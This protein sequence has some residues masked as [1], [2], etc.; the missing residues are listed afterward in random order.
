MRPEPAASESGGPRGGLPWSARSRPA[1]DGACA[2]GEEPASTR[3]RS[4]RSSLPRL[5]LREPRVEL[6]VLEVVTVFLGRELPV[7]HFLAVA[8]EGVDHHLLEPRVAL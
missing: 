7:S 4:A 3:R 6:R 8:A 2:S 1:T 5:Q